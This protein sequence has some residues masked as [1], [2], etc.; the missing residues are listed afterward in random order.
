M[1]RG[2]VT[3]GSPITSVWSVDALRSSALASF[4]MRILK[5]E[6]YLSSRRAPTPLELLEFVSLAAFELNAEITASNT[7][8]DPAQGRGRGDWHM[9]GDPT[10]DLLGTARPVPN[11]T[12]TWC[13]T[14]AK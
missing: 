3:A 11:T 6:C 1:R 12:L 14:P 10:R 9:T 7:A 5:V 2:G 4:S 13:F 8:V